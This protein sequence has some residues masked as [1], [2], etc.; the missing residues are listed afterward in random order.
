M[1]LGVELPKQVF[2][3]PWVLVNKS[4]M[5]KSVGN[6]MYTDDLVKYFGVDQVDIMSSMKFLFLQDGNITFEL[7]IERSNS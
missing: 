3:H 2:G 6:T 4:K 5:S 7:L 1:A